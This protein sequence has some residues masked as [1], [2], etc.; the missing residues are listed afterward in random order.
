MASKGKPAPSGSKYITAFRKQR[1]AFKRS[2]E[3]TFGSF[4]CLARR[5]DLED[6][7]ASG[8]LPVSLTKIVSDMFS[9]QPVAGGEIS[10]K[11]MALF[12]RGIVCYAVVEPKIVVDDAEPGE[13]EIHYL[14]I[15]PTERMQIA[16]WARGNAPDVPVETE[17]GSTTVAS[18]EKFRQ[19]AGLHV[20]PGTGPDL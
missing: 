12:I 3:M 14:E 9:G 15:D 17:G 13:G 5:L 6:W 10:G 8:T 7:M 20:V 1:G 19:D 4:T 16:A 2:V 11:E 18:I